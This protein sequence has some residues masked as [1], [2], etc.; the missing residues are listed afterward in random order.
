[1]AGNP[2]D[3]LNKIPVLYKVIALSIILVGI[4]VG[5]YMTTWTELEKKSES[6]RRERDDLDRKYKEQ[7][8]VAD[9]LPTF[10][11]N[12]KKLEE[13]LN[14]ALTQLP[15]SKEI[16]SLLRDIFT[17]GMK[18]GVE[19]KSFEPQKEA[20]KSLY[21]ELPLKLQIVGGYHE[22]AVFFDRIGKM[23]RIV[24]VSN[25]DVNSS[26]GKDGEDVLNIACTATTFMFLGGGS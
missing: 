16:P 4:V 11:Q 3:K 21:A 18:S 13:D 1:M 25:L 20:N 22:I 19:F 5:Q 7:K 10:Q 12:T 26:K 6:L 14:A 23:S 15:R 8:A 2:L 9:N 17:L 24:N